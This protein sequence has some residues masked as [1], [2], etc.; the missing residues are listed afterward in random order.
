MSRDTDKEERDEDGRKD[1]SDKES[2]VKAEVTE[3]TYEGEENG[4]DGGEDNIGEE[5]ESSW[6]PE[7][8]SKTSPSYKLNKRAD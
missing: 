2:D 1:D 5:E 4:D 6:T 8:D 7:E 3:E